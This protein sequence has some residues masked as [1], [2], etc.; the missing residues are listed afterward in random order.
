MILRLQ[1]YRQ[2]L[3]LVLLRHTPLEYQFSFHCSKHKCRLI[4]R[5][6]V[7]KMQEPEPEPE[8]EQNRHLSK[9]WLKRCRSD[10]RPSYIPFHH[11]C[12]LQCSPLLRWC[13]CSRVLRRTGKSRR[14]R[15]YPPSYMVQWK[16]TVCCS[17]KFCLPQPRGRN[18]PVGSLRTKTRLPSQHPDPCPLLLPRTMLCS[19]ATLDCSRTR[20]FGSPLLSHIQTVA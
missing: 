3:K 19:E 1:W 9:C 13:V 18:T 16:W 12:R 17:A 15:G 8:P 10:P 4:E 7:P 20:T 6:K 5:N 14:Q 2:N 11:T